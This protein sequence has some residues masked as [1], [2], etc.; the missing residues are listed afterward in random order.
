WQG[1]QDAG[2]GSLEGRRP[3]G[4]LAE[5]AGGRRGSKRQS[6]SHRAPRSSGGGGRQ[7]RAGHSRGTARPRRLLIREVAAEHWIT[8]PQFDSRPRVVVCVVVALDQLP[9]PLDARVNCQPGYPAP[10]WG[11]S[12][13]VHICRHRSEGG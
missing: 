12:A 11:P 2:V 6:V 8:A 1:T 13:L 5:I 4:A 7:D 3:R 10:L 9:S